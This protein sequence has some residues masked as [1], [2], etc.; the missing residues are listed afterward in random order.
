MKKLFVGIVAAI[1]LIATGAWAEQEMTVKYVFTNQS[2]TASGNVTSEIIDL[3]KIAGEGF[4]AIQ[5]YNGELTESP[6]LT[7]QY[8][9]SIDGTDFLE[10]STAVDI[11]TSFATSGGPGSDGKDIFYFE[12]EPAAFMKIFVQETAGANCTS[13]LDLSLM[14]Q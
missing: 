14:V 2:V 9:L 7:V 13:G 12:P 1:A 5:I 10:P 8:Q 4:F 11:C 6:T 3:S